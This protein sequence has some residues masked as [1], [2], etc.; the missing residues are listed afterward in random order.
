MTKPLT[1]DALLRRKSRPRS[2]AKACH[3][4]R[5]EGGLS[6]SLR[7]TPDEVVGPLTHALGGPAKAFKVTDVRT[8]TPP[9]LHVEW[10]TLAEKWEVEDV[11]GLA[12]NLNDLFRDEPEVGVL[13]VL[14][15][16]EDMLQV[17][18]VP[19]QALGPLL[20]ARLLDEARNV[21]TLVALREGSQGTPG[22]W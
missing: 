13:V 8:G 16:L 19:K 21:R 20:D 22:D 10:R 4:G 1:W 12:H 3:E 17:W 6:I 18:P 5:L 11:A 9:V 15:D 14:A 7:A 2:L